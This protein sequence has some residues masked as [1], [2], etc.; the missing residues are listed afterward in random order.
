[1]LQRIGEKQQGSPTN[2][3]CWL[4]SEVLQTRA[5]HEGSNNDADTLLEA[6][7]YLI[8]L[9]VKTFFICSAREPYFSSWPDRSY[10]ACYAPEKPLTF[11]PL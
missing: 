11:D 8:Q 4:V 10:S 1:M 6:Q 3:S 2:N 5:C 9:R 7:K